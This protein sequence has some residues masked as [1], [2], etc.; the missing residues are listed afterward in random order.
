MSDTIND[1]T[2]QK[3]LKAFSRIILQ[4]VTELY[5]KVVPN[6]VKN[7]KNFDKRKLSDSEIIALAIIGELLGMDSERCW[8]GF[9][10]R[11][12]SE[13]FGEFCDRTR[14]NRTKRALIHIIRDIQKETIKRLPASQI[15]IIDSF[16]LPVCKFGRAHFHK[17]FNGY[18]ANYGYCPSKKEYYYG[19]KFH[20]I[21][22]EIGLPATFTITGANI[23]DRE[24]LEELNEEAKFAILIGDKG[25][26]GA[27]SPGTKVIALERKNAKNPLYS[28]EQRQIIFKIRRRIETTISQLTDTLNIQKVR[29]K[30][31][32]GLCT[33]IVFKIL[34]FSTAVLINKMLGAENIFA[35]KNFIFY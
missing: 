2:K 29:A 34:A 15:G 24:V 31:F 21:I 17:T 1:N 9:A 13:V 25:F 10:K 32:W 23:D 16:P 11:N 12:L 7:R 33:N 19:Y 30:S 35:I 5:K 6:C 28:K 18:G 14:Y 4:I 8:Y 27:K 26:I 22:N 20:L 3:D